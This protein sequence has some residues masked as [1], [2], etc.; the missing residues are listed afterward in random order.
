MEQDFHTQEPLPS[1][2][3]AQRSRSVSP[4]LLRRRLWQDAAM[5]LGAWQMVLWQ[6][7][8]LYAEVDGVCYQKISTTE[9]RFPPAAASV[10]V[11]SIVCP[12]RA[13]TNW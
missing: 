10:P 2:T 1:S 7:R 9:V 4:P 11:K 3:S 8:W 6:P 12:A 5:K 13:E